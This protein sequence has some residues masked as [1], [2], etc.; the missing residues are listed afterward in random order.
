MKLRAARLGGAFLVVAL[1]GFV[2]GLYVDQAF[3]G[4]PYL[5]YLAN[6]SVGRV[7][8]TELE[9]AIQVIQ[10]N[11]VDGNLNSTKLA[12]GSVQGLVASLGDPFSAYYDPAQYKRLTD[13]LQG[14]YSGVGIYLSFSA[15]YPVIAGTVPDSPAAKAGLQAGDQIVKV[16]D[17]DMKGAT[18]EQ[19]T[20]LIQGPNG[21]QVTL[22]IARGTTT[23][24][25]TITRAEIHVASV[26]SA[27][28]G[29]QVLYVR[30]Y[31]FGATTS[32]EFADALASGLRGAKGVVL[33]L[34]SDPGGYISAADDVIS[35]FVT[36]GETFE[37]RDRNHNVERHDATGPHS[38]PSV[39]LVVL[40]DANS[41]SASEIVAGS[42]QVHHRAKL[43]G[44]KTFGK[45]SV[46]LDF[47]LRDGSDLHLTIKRWYLPNGVTIDHVG[48][49]PDVVVTLASPDDAFDVTK[50]SQGYAK[51]TQLNAA[52]KALA[53]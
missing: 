17:K 18:A 50:P 48:L 7:D 53:G 47:P 8:I 28:I 19:A 26:R 38:A 10:A 35:Q 29:N 15:G 13:S 49:M 5:P 45:G 22:T 36:S 43:V 6:H 16:A 25:V 46:Q 37:L 34:R 51:D 24:T 14:Q 42:L 11:Y 3:P 44:T 33:D 41:A 2:S 21:S 4:S 23:L 32:K 52:L 30:I 40:V 27:V 1:L 39:P 31:Q 9:Q 12:H 20:A